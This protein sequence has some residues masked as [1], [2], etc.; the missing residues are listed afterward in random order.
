[1][2]VVNDRPTAPLPLDPST[3]RAAL[4]VASAVLGAGLDDGHADALLQGSSRIVVADPVAAALAIAI[5]WTSVTKHRKDDPRSGVRIVAP[6]AAT[7]GTLRRKGY[8]ATTAFAHRPSDADPIGL[9]VVVEPDL[10]PSD[11]LRRVL[12]APDSTRTVVV[13]RLAAA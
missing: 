4:H 3:T 7:V 1:M 10:M 2:G 12:D 13:D 5:A 9:L 8:D 6:D 11:A